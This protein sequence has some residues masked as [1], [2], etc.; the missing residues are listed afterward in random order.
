[1]LLYQ[2]YYWIYSLVEFRGETV[3]FV[4][5]YEKMFQAKYVVETRKKCQSVEAVTASFNLIITVL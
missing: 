1:M 2:D 3:L 4:E 5:L